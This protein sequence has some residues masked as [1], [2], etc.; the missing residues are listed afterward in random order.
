MHVT[1]HTNMR[2]Y[3]LSLLL[4]LLLGFQNGRNASQTQRIIKSDDDN[5]DNDNDDDDDDD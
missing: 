4:F 2:K 5:D 3:I 1:I